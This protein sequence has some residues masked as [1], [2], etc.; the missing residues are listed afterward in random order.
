MSL[1]QKSTLIFLC[2]LLSMSC[3]TTRIAKWSGDDAKIAAGA[4]DEAASLESEGDALYSERKDLTKLL[5]STMKWELASKIAPSPTLF[6]KLSRAHYLCAQRTINDGNKD[7][8]F[9]HYVQGL[10]FAERGLKMVAP[11]FVEELERASSYEKALSKVPKQAGALLYWYAMN[12]EKWSHAQGVLTALRYKD[13]VRAVTIKA[14]EFENDVEV[15]A[16]ISDTM[17]DSRR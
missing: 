12:L 16:Q 4:P 9:Q 7:E 2:A 6:K 14:V 1:S 15:Y 13:A 3:A 8:S 5:A 10:S 17:K 11:A